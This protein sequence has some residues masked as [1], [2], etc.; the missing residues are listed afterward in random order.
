MGPSEWVVLERDRLRIACAA[1]AMAAA[2]AHR[3]LGRGEDALAMARRAIALEPMRDSGWTLLVEI[4]QD[5]GDRTAA[6]VTRREFRRMRE[7]L[8]VDGLLT[9]P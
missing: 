6:E 1:T 8:D 4:Q 7:E 2:Q 9:R 5:M 3:T